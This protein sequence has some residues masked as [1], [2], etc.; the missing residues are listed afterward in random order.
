MTQY[1]FGSGA[2]YQNVQASDDDRA[3]VADVISNAYV[4]GQLSKEEHD[5][6]IGAV[7]SASS[8]AELAN[9]TRDLSGPQLLPPPQAIPRPPMAP[10]YTGYNYAVDAVA[11]PPKDRTVSLIL[12]IVLGT[13][14]I[15]R[16]YTGYVGLGILYLFTGGLFGIGWI[17]D[18][19]MMATGSYRDKWGRPLAG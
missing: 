10:A 8:L 4:Y 11:G 19:I 5:A 13:V 9:L 3:K 15:H 1:P 16:F 7:W 17:I 6:R 2:Q 12:A 14:G 18:I